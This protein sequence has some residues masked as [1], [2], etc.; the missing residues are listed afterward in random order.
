MLGTVIKR[1]LQGVFV[2]FCVI[3]IS[4][5]ILRMIPGDPAKVMA[6]NATEE[7]LQII[8]DSMGLSKPILVQFQMYA[9]N[10]LHGNMGD[11]YF[12]NDTVVN[13]IAQTVPLS[14]I[15]LA[16]STAI[17]LIL[18]LILGSISGMNGNSWIDRVISSIAVLLQS[19]PNY[20]VSS[21]L[22]IL[23]SVKAGIFPS[24]DY[25]GW[26]SC[27]L[28]VIA[29]V[30]PLA[31]VLTKVIRSSLM[32]S[33]SQEFVKVAYARGVS[34]TAIYF[35]Y[36]LRNSTIPALISLGSQLG[37]LVGSIVV[38]EY[39]FSFPGIGYTVL[40]AILRRDYNLVQGIIILFSLF[41][42]VINIII[43]LGTIRLDPRLRKAE[44][45][46]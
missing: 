28:P 40:N 46:L 14:A 38:V 7:Q 36:A 12:K 34:K 21:M 42:I 19:M 29:L 16:V 18:A 39:V 15:L 30:L 17:S 2:T 23:L 13:I 20:W 8:R 10:L 9:Q 31:A 25:S 26:K 44:G 32:D 35:K 5:V 22:I 4:F 24:M 27:V 3:F 6:P 1:I 33:Y 11:S 45:S 41:F 43:D 37:F